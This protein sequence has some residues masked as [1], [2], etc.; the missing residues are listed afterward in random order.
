MS[1]VIETELTGK[2]IQTR[3]VPCKV[4]GKPLEIVEFGDPYDQI[5]DYVHIECAEPLAVG[6]TAPSP[7]PISELFKLAEDTTAYARRVLPVELESD[8]VQTEQSIKYMYLL[9]FA[10]KVLKS[11]EAVILLCRS[12]YGEDAMIITRSIAEAVINAARIESLPPEEG[13]KRYAAYKIALQWRFY[14]R[15]KQLLIDN[16]EPAER[17][18][19]PESAT[20]HENQFKEFED[21]FL[22]DR[23]K[24]RDDPGNIS[25][26]WLTSRSEETGKLKEEDIYEM[27]RKLDGVEQHRQKLARCDEYRTLLR[28]EYE[29]GSNY[30]HSN[31]VAVESYFDDNEA[32]GVIFQSLPSKRFVWVRLWSAVDGLI[33]ML[34]I[35]NRVEP[36]EN[37]EELPALRHRWCQVAED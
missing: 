31:P 4:C 2:A 30:A 7:K 36:L 34:E 1:K 15:W 16:P 28:T 14:L 10:H 25:K 19:T 8:A 9:G 35:V 29:V 37:N 23:A 12:G 3:E 27:A 22:I 24:G 21:W 18:F 6:S 33:H 17:F 11:T 26:N 5:G 13:A 20:E 32:G